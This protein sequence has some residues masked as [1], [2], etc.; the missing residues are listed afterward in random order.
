MIDPPVVAR[1]ERLI[2]LAIRMERLS[3]DWMENIKRDEK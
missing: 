1:A 3:P 2:D